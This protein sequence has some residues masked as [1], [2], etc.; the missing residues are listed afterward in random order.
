MLAPRASFRYAAL[1]TGASALLC[2]CQPTPHPH[3]GLTLTERGTIAI[4]VSR[5]DY[6]PLKE[7]S[8]WTL[9]FSDN[10]AERDKELWALPGQ[11]N[12]RLIDTGVPLAAVGARR[13]AV[14][15]TT[16]YSDKSGADPDEFVVGKVKLNG[17]SRDLEE[18]NARAQGC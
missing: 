6:G 5:C 15:G 2:G 12:Q 17:K 8:L 10:V 1:F 3:L 9:T 14:F 7:A 18:L 4:V 16:K 13:V 11:T